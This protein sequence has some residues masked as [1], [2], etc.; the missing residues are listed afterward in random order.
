MRATR[1][2]L[3]LHGHY[4]RRYRAS[5]LETEAHLERFEQAAVNLAA[6]PGKRG[7]LEQLEQ[8]E[9]DAVN[10]QAD[11]PGDRVPG[12]GPNVG[13]RRAGGGSGESMTWSGRKAA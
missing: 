10:A 8:L 4:H 3:L 1:P 6:K 7:K 9:L 5:F 13:A 12:S 2:R 11:D